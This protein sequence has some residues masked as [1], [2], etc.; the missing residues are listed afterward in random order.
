M[1]TRESFEGFLED[2]REYEI[3]F[4]G[5]YPAELV[6]TRMPVD[7]VHTID[8]Y[9][10]LY[11]LG[12][13]IMDHQGEQ[14]EL[15]VTMTATVQSTGSLYQTTQSYVTEDI[16]WG[17]RFYQAIV[18]KEGKGYF[19]EE[20]DWDKTLDT[21]MSP[22]SQETRDFKEVARLYQNDE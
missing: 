2:L 20:K 12:Q 22:D 6:T 17:H 7:F 19:V 1:K 4:D 3:K 13:E 18:K 5:H 15:I 14:L 16:L 21:K 8:K 11:E 9:S 10:P